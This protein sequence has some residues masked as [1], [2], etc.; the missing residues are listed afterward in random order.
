MHFLMNHPISKPITALTDSSRRDLLE[1]SLDAAAN[2]R[3]VFTRFYPEAARAAAANADAMRA[4]GVELPSALAGLPVSIKDLV[5]VAGEPT[6]AGS[7]L[8]KN[9]APALHDAPVVRRL[10]LAGAAIVGKTN[11]TEFAF[12]GLG[13]NPH[14]GTPANPADQ[15]V[16]RIPGGSSSGAAASVAAGICVAALGS[17]TGGSIRIPAAMCGLV[18]FKSTA[19]RVPTTGAIPLS[20]TLD[21]LCA[22]TRSVDDCILVDRLI[23]DDLLNIPPLPLKGLRLALP[24]TQMLDN[25]DHHVATSFSAALTRLSAAGAIIL[26][27]PFLPL[28]ELI[29]LNKFSGAEAY[30]WHRELLTRHEAEYDPRV[31]KRIIL[32]ATLSAAD[33]ID[34]HAKRCD[35]IA[36]MEQLMVPFDAL[37]MP[38]VAIVAPPLADLEASDEAY[39]AANSLVLRN[40]STINFLDGCAISLPCHAPGSLP[41]GLTVAGAAMQD[42]KILAVARAVEQCLI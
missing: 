6:M 5:D 8:L 16:V 39:F 10:R 40:P 30:A 41:V 37:I 38:T 11:M 33:Y 34:L 25:L 36:R 9:A 2:T 21:T 17:D 42:A 24:R 18:G 29:H 4:A 1:T 3:S 14:Y 12:S 7:T 15:R 20:T 13:L 26:D 22:M 27:T 23:A 28:A 19:R 35:W 31:S 32:G